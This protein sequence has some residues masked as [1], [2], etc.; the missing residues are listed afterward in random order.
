MSVDTSRSRLANHLGLAVTIE[1]EDEE[2]GVVSPCSDVPAKVDAP[3]TRAVEFV[4]IYENITCIAT[5][6]IVFLV[7]R[8]PFHEKLVLTI[9][10]HVA[11][12]TVVGRVGVTAALV[13]AT[14]RSV[15]AHGLE[16]PCPRRYSRRCLGHH[17]TYLGHH[18]VDAVGAAPGVDKRGGCREVGSNDLSVAQQVKRGGGVVVSQVSPAH[19]LP[20]ARL[21][22]Q[23]H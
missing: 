3:E 14:L 10:I 5:L 13:G 16:G 12:A 20:A 2:L 4:A 22:R 15:K 7:G 19:E 8:V 23:C 9:A 18:L 21:G 11:H 17:S 6:R 1:V